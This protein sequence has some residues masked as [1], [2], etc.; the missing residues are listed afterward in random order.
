MTGITCAVAGATSYAS[1]ASLTVGTRSGG[2]IVFYGY[3]I[4]S[5]AITPNTFGPF[6]ISDLEWNSTNEVYF[7]VDGE[8]PNAG[9]QTITILNIST[10]LSETYNRTSATY[11]VGTGTAWTW[12]SVTNPFGTTI[13]GTPTI[14]VTWI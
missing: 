1:T 11:A 3:T 12:P 7:R 2:G 5:G 4:I 13:S 10:G 9:W 14:T 8:A 6:G